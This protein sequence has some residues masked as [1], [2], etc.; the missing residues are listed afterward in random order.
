MG[1]LSNRVDELEKAEAQGR[2]TGEDRAYAAAEAVLFKEALRAR[3]NGDVD[4]WQAWKDR[5]E[6]KPAR[7]G[8][9]PRQAAGVSEDAADFSRRIMRW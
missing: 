3:H 7:T 4:T 5:Q 2:D 6:S 8:D 9:G 1:R